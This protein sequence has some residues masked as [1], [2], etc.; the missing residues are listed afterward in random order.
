[1]SPSIPTGWE[2]LLDEGE[3]IVWQGR[4]VAG[5]SFH[6]TDVMGALMGVFFMVFSVF[7]M[8]MATNITSNFNGFGGIFPKL[9]PL[10]GIPFFLIGFYNA[11]GHV[12]W[13][14]FLRSKTH[15]TLSSKRAFIATDH[16]TQGKLLTDYPID[17]HTDLILKIG[18]PDTVW[19]AGKHIGF[20]NIEDGRAV[21][22]LMRQIQKETP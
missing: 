15:Y 12:F 9:F 21:H 22:K 3:T 11:I 20:A 1:M 13:Q 14:A 8:G 2:G 7:W 19:F 10:F 4:P 6:G 18:P 5:L 17:A 16:P